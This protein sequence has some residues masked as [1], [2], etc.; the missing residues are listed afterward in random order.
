VARRCQDS[1]LTIV[2]RDAFGGSAKFV[3]V[4]NVS[5]RQKENAA[6]EQHTVWNCA[7]TYTLST[8]DARN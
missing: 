8:T 2:L 7:P 4:A 6:T 5:P 1:K 3:I